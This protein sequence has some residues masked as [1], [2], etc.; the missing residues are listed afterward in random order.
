MNQYQPTTRVERYS[1]YIPNDT[2][3]SQMIMIHPR[4]PGIGSEVGEIGFRDKCVSACFSDYL[5]AVEGG[6]S[7][8]SLEEFVADVGAL[9]E[10]I[11]SGFCEE[12]GF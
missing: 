8:E 7:R 3:D 4:Q 2:S 10:D 6:D 1:A 5:E 11:S 9:E 12:R